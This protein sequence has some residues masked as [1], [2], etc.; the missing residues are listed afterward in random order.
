[1]A[2]SNHI[3]IV[4]LDAVAL[5]SHLTAC[6]GTY[7]KL[8]SMLESRDV[9]RIT[10]RYADNRKGTAGGTAKTR[11]QTWLRPRPAAAGTPGKVRGRFRAR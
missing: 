3:D 6:G 8:Y 9:M 2:H 11:P 7:E 4:T 1:M 5:L 10:S